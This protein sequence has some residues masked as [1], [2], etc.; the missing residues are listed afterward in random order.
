MA[1]TCAAAAGGAP[2]GPRRFLPASGL[3]TFAG[4]RGLLPPLFR[5]LDRTA[6][7]GPRMGPAQYPRHRARG[8]RRP[9]NGTG[10]D[11]LAS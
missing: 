9:F 7:L 6:R 3:E 2:D 11:G 1:I 8:N 5:T 10:G 4:F